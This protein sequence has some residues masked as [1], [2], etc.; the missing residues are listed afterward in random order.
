MFLVPEPGTS[1][2]I[3]SA[4]ASIHA[5][6]A[7][8]HRRCST[9]A[10]CGRNPWACSNCMTP[11]R[12]QV[13]S[14]PP[15]RVA[16]HRGDLVPTLRQRRTGQQTGRTGAEDQDLHDEPRS[17]QRRQ[18]S[19]RLGQD[20]RPSTPLDTVLHADTRRNTAGPRTQRSVPRVRWVESAFDHGSDCVP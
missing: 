20:G 13:P 16:V 18:V 12:R 17:A 2:I 19:T 5:L 14:L 8:G 10:T 15:G 3:G 11:R 7:E 9:S 6:Y 4:P 1:T